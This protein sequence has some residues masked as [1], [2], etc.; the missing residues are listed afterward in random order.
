MRGQEA[1]AAAKTG[2]ALKR[3]QADEALSDLRKTA[4]CRCLDG[5]C[6]RPARTASTQCSGC[7]RRLHVATCGGF[8]SSARA[9]AGVLKCFYC[10]ALDMAPDQV[11]TAARLDAAM[12]TMIIQLSLG[13]EGTAAA[14]ATY[15][16][17]EQDFALQQGLEGQELLLARHRRET[18]LAF[19]T[20]C[21][22]DA[23][24]ARSMRALW[25]TLPSLFKL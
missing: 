1:A 14:A 5:K 2:G 3:A 17:L 21:F 15:N 8:G 16:Q 23:G 7:P 11:P 13:Q 4:I 19:T 12:V 18:F 6:E 24:R 22:R 25:R 9:A 10:H 20:Y